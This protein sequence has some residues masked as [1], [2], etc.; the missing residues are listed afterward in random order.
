MKIITLKQPWATLVAEGIKNYEFRS[1]KTKYRGDILIHAGLGVDKEAIALYENTNLVFPK[2]RIL[3]IVRVNNC[4]EI[5]KDFNK[6]IKALNNITYGNKDRS[7]YAWE[8]TNVRKINSSE[9]ISGKLGLWNI[10]YA[11]EKITIHNEK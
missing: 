11:E 6:Y 8:L 9:T 4:I 10:D 2:S 7:G 1:W 5:N 3:A